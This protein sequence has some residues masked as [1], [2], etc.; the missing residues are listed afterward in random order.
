MTS[1]YLYLLIDLL[2]LAVPL[3]AG[4]YLKFPLYKNWK[5]IAIGLVATAVFFLLL[6]ELLT[7]FG[8]LS[9]NERYITGIYVS[10]LPVEELLF[11]LFIPFAGVFT[12]FMLNHIFEKDRLFPH[13]ELISSALIIVLLIAGMYHKEKLYT[14]AAFLLPAV[15]LTFQ[16]LKLRPRYMGRF[17]SAYAFLLVPLVIVNGVL[18]GAFTDEEVVRYNDTQYL[19]V[20]VGT[21]PIENFFYSMLLMVMPIA[22]FE[23]LDEYYYYKKK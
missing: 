22:I 8:I 10:S 3:A 2:V 15:F 18:T 12:Y 11:F 20:L 19:G 5:Y 14:A 6:D 9:V 23:W 7:Q 16:M 17:Y 13:Q 21:I 4:F 1:K